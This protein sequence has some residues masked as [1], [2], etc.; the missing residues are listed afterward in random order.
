MIGKV[1]A[2]LSSLVAA[3]W[4]AVGAWRVAH[5]QLPGSAAARRRASRDLTRDTDLSA[6]CGKRHTQSRHQDADADGQEDEVHE[7]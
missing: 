6:V 2:A 4:A 1:G 5:S 7:T 3:L